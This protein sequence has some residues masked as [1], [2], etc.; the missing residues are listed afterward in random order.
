LPLPATLSMLLG[1]RLSE[2]EGGSIRLYSDYPFEGGF[3]SG[4]QLDSFEEDALRQ[5]R[6][7]PNQP[8][9]RFVETEQ[10]TLLRYATADIMREACVDCHNNHE[11]SP[12]TE[13][14]KGD[15]RGV[16]ELT[17][18]M[19]VKVLQTQSD[20]RSTVFLLLGTSIM[21]LGVI[22]MAAMRLR[23][24]RV[25]AQKLARD[26]IQ[27]NEER[28]SIE[29][30]ALQTQ[31]LESLGLLAGG[32]AHDFNNL[33]VSILGNAELAEL[34]L[35]SSSPALRHLHLVKTAGDRAAGL[36][37]Q[38]LAYAG[39]GQLRTR[40]LDLN[41]VVEEISQ[42][43]HMAVARKAEVV[44]ELY[45][46]LPLIEADPTQLEQVV[47]N[48]ITNAAEAISS[49]PGQIHIRTG[50]EDQD[51]TD[52]KDSHVFLEVQDNGCGMD[53]STRVQMFDPF[54]SNKGEGRGLGLSAMLGI[55]RAHNGVIQVNSIEGLGTTIRVVLPC[56]PL[57]SPMTEIPKKT[58]PLHG[59]G[60]TI[61]VVDDDEDSRLTTFDLLVTR[62][63]EVIA[64]SSG[65]EGIALLKENGDQVFAVVLDMTMPGMGGVEA[66]E[67]MEAM[68]P[69]IRVVM[70]SGFTA[71]VRLR[72]LLAD[73]RIRFLGKPFRMDELVGILLL[74]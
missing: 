70:V 28:E 41:Q 29:L 34:H 69:G 50:I 57:L 45:P 54:F 42:L 21:T 62:G 12:Y 53:E 17:R 9:Y 23:R 14:E 25:L 27:A 2:K 46:E 56:T 3:N 15:V 5:L 8:V 10:G 1:T 51:S 60:R 48:L 61:L 22:G 16:L 55:V 67:S 73:K 11:D 44:F 65:P 64:A 68:R 43:L 6:E 13:W 4:R 72:G 24:A 49:A 32:I 18:P 39:H 37:N 33:L 26:A 36:T 38:L 74:E 40:V 47:L 7:T 30:Q 31:K 63:F 19:S 52:S 58:V 59:E 20:I 66:F 35:S 71:E